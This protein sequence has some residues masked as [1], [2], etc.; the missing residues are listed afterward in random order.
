[1][2]EETSLAPFEARP[3]KPID[4]AKAVEL[5]MAAFPDFFLTFL[6]PAFLRLLYG[7]YAADEHAVALAGERDGQII[8]TVLGTSRPENFYKRMAQKHFVLFAWACFKP[9]LRRPAIL[10]RLVRALLYRGDP[11]LASENGALLASICVDP[12]SRGSGI[13]NAMLMAFEREM[14]QRN[15]AFV[16]LTTDRDENQA[17]QGF[18]GKQGWSLQAEFTTPEGRRMQRYWKWRPVE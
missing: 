9:L 13:G 12:N 7:F 1:M 2:N 4:L 17:V 5:H 11:P 18:Y 6:G 10:P 14:W 15:A 16:Y 8:A 3:L